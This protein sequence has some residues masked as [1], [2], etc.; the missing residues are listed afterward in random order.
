M[1]ERIEALL[2][3]ISPDLQELNVDYLV[4]GSC[5]LVLAGVHVDEI[6]DLDLF[7]TSWDVD[8]LKKVWAN[9]IRKEFRPAHTE[10]F[11][12]NFARF[13]FGEMDVEVMGNLEVFRDHQWVSLKVSDVNAIEIGNLKVKIP[14]LEEQKR[15]FYFF[16]RTKD[17]LKAKRIENILY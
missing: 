4:I 14:T 16:G 3:F 12:S 9:R 8:Q 5:A 11:R 2:N 1:K 15:I 13:D 6:K 17:I 7:T 10:L